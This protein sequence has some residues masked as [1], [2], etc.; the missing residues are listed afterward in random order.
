MDLKGIEKV[1]ATQKEKQ[2]ELTPTLEYYGALAAIQAKIQEKAERVKLTASKPEVEITLKGGAPLSILEKVPVDV[3]LFKQ[4]FDEIARLFKKHQTGK[5]DEIDQIIHT[6]WDYGLIVKKF[7]EEDL[8]GLREMA[9]FNRADPALF[10]Y[11]VTSALK[12]FYRKFAEGIG[13]FVKSEWWMENRCPV[14][15]EKANIGRLGEDN[16]RFLVCPLCEHEWLYKRLA[17]PFCGNADHKELTQL[18]VEEIPGYQI[19]ACDKCR[20]YLKVVD[21]RESTD[22]GL[23]PFLA[24]LVTQDLDQAAQSKEYK[25]E[26]E[27][28]AN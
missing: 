15:G 4:A 26:P 23:D 28:L 2:P 21:Q 11:I 24:D 8:A 16:Q 22:K 5:D 25:R 1:V 14:C 13:P 17:C 18:T 20:G 12:P 19:H 7:F 3:K 6:E 27:N 10:A 9:E